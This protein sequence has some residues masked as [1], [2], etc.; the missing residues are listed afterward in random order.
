MCDTSI[1]ECW[2]LN[3]NLTSI[4][5]WISNITIK[6]ITHYTTGV[7]KRA[8]QFSTSQKSQKIAPVLI[9]WNQQSLCL[10]IRF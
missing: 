8:V 4:N 3:L 1:Q 9:M 2:Q 10:H 6:I 5:I 7:S